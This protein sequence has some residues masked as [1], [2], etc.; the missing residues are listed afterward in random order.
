M[1]TGSLRLAA[2]AVAVLTQ[3]TAASAHGVVDQVAGIVG[4]LA[5]GQHTLSVRP[6]AS[7]AGASATVA[8]DVD[9]DLV[10]DPSLSC[11]LGSTC[12]A[13]VPAGT[14]V[15]LRASPGTNTTFT[16]WSGCT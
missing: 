5:V 11:A 13:S 2:L 1:N 6:S 9:G 16:S 8:I 10:D 3:P 14:T 7:G 4:A 12:T 15:V